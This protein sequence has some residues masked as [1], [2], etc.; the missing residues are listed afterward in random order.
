[1][2]LAHSTNNSAGSFDG[3]VVV[4]DREVVVVAV[5]APLDVVEL[6]VL[7]TDAT[8]GLFELPP[9]PAIRIPLTS[10]AAA[11]RRTGRVRGGR[12]RCVLSCIW[13]PSRRRRV[14][15][16]VLRDQRLQEGLASQA[17]RPSSALGN[18]TPRASSA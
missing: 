13:S 5:L 2:Q 12:V 16:P 1:M 8:A 10:A 18:T 3:V 11:V 15:A 9:H 17:S 4:F 7:L 6:V 14:C